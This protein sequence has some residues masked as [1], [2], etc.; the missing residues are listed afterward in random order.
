MKIPKK[1]SSKEP[2]AKKPAPAAP[3]PCS[4]EKEKE[5]T[6]SEKPQLVTKL[7]AKTAATSKKGD[8]RKKQAET[9]D[10][11]KPRGPGRPP[12]RDKVSRILQFCWLHFHCSRSE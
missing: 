10:G 6:K 3:K 12:H 8:G 11:S 1:P 5:K 2:E 9:R 7:S 4:K